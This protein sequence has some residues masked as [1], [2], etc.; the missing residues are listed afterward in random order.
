MF[1]YEFTDYAYTTVCLA[2]EALDETSDDI[3]YPEAAA[4]TYAAAAETTEY[5]LEEFDYYTLTSQ[6]N[7]Y[8]TYSMTVTFNCVNFI[9]LAQDWLVEETTYEEHD[10]SP[11]LETV[12]EPTP[13]MIHPCH[14]SQ[15]HTFSISDYIDDNSIYPL[16]EI[17]QFQLPAADQPVSLETSVFQVAAMPFRA[18]DTAYPAPGTAA[19]AL[20]PASTLS[21]RQEITVL[22]FNQVDDT[23]TPTLDS[24][25]MSMAGP[26]QNLTFSQRAAQ[27]SRSPEIIGSEADLLAMNVDVRH[28]PSLD[29]LDPI[30]R[31]HQ[32]LIQARI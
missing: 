3:A 32:L 25:T 18:A 5:I 31:L 4:I 24:F 29:S 8:N 28:V 30:N 13:C 23:P 26:Q 17:T 21:S 20:T 6:F 16:A 19:S 15:P 10:Q 7:S 14:Q 1:I 27:P 2:P 22:L 11:S 9:S 12:C